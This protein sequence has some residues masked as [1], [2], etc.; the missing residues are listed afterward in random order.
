MKYYLKHIFYKLSCYF[1]FFNP[2]FYAFKSDIKKLKFTNKERIIF[3]ISLFGKIG[4][5]KYL[6]NLIDVLKDYY[7]CIVVSDKLIDDSWIV[8]SNFKIIDLNN[9]NKS[10]MIKFGLKF[11]LINFIDPVKITFIS[12]SSSYNF[13]NYIPKSIYK[14]KCDFISVFFSE[15]SYS[16]FDNKSMNNLVLKSK[17][18][19]SDNEYCLYQLK[20]KYGVIDACKFKCLYNYIL[21]MTAL[22]KDVSSFITTSHCFLSDETTIKKQSHFLWAGRLDEDK[23]IP[24]LIEIIRSNP[25]IIFEIFGYQTQVEGNNYMYQLTRMPN[26]KMNGGYKQLSEIQI[27]KFSG[28]I[29][30]SKME[31]LP[32]VLLEIGILGLP[33]IAPNVGGIPELINSDTGYLVNN[34]IESYNSAIG[35]IIS[36]QNQAYQKA[37]KLCELIIN[38]HALENYILTVK[39]IFG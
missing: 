6:I 19:I 2:Y 39:T 38:R 37:K 14:K 3:D 10:G 7:D 16:I 32:N 8:D 12:W 18:I 17:Y 1:I 29:F 30:T 21:N 23:N 28:F 33:V 27:D 22:D 24:L 9:Y 4:T 35:E 36:N 34:T 26:V 31:G 5:T 15:F 20:Q 25:D 13:F 11:Y